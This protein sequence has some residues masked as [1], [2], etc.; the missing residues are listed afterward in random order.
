MYLPVPTQPDCATAWREAM[1][2]V[3][4]HGN[5]AH[6]VILDIADPVG[7]ATLAD[8]VVATVDAFLQAKGV[9]PIETVANTLFPAALHRRYGAPAFYDRFM[10]RVLPAAGR[11][12]R[13]SGY[14]FE[15][16]INMPTPGGT[17]INQLADIIDR[18]SDPAVKAR[19]KFELTLFDPARDVSRSP[20]GGQCLSHGSFKVR[21]T[22]DGDRLDLT[23][24]YRNH[25]YVEKLLGNLIGL[26]RLMAFVAEETKIGVGSLTIVST[27]AVIDQPRASRAE[28]KALLQACDALVADGDGLQSAE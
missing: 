25:Y 14:Y 16:M 20:Y 15:R 7:G 13:W 17:V 9:K 6:N 22:P 8:P 5:E 28:I 11:D 2:A 26:G 10:T 24:M 27:H 3:I 19:N 1:R 4:R 18:I 12:D 23:V 21:K